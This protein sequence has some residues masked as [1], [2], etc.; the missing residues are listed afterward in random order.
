MEN[1]GLNWN[2][3]VDFFSKKYVSS[4]GAFSGSEASINNNVLEVNLKSKSKFI[5]L[6]RNMDKLISDFVMNSTGNRYEVKFNEPDVVEVIPKQDEIIKRMLE[7]NAAKAAKVAQTTANTE[8]LKASKEVKVNTMP[9]GYK[10]GN[11]ANSAPK[12]PVTN[13]APTWQP[14]TGNEAP[15]RTPRKRNLDMVEDVE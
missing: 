6:S 5:M 7:E 15:R 8:N 9:E 3:V 12:A 2:E 10:A 1:N 14:P 13:N 4:R 11:T